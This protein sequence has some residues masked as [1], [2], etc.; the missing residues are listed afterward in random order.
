ML[1]DDKNLHRVGVG[2]YIQNDKGYF[3]LAK[4]KRCILLFVMWIWAK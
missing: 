1:I 4:S 2:M 3:V